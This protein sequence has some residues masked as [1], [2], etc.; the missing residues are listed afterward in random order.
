MSDLSNLYLDKTGQRV[1]SA[2]SLVNDKDELIDQSGKVIEAGGEDVK[3][4]SHSTYRLAIVS[5]ERSIELSLEVQHVL[6]SHVVTTQGAMMDMLSDEDKEAV[7]NEGGLSDDV[8]MKYAG[9]MLAVQ[10]QVLG[11]LDPKQMFSLIKMLFPHVIINGETG[12]VALGGHFAKNKSH[13]LP[14]LKEIIRV[15]SFL[16]LDL[17][18][19]LT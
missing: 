3:S 18:A 9:Q 14:V 6:Q 4:E 11:K 12:L 2:G 13:V 1:N 10:G 7:K 19:L 8:S 5:G 17:T 16:E 15:N